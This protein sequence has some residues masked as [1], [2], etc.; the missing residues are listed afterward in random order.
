MQIKK[1]PRDPRP[2]DATD[3]YNDTAETGLDAIP[4][5]TDEPQRPSWRREA[6]SAPRPE[7]TA[8][9]TP[10]S[11]A[12][13]PAASPPAPVAPVARGES[14]VDAHS[15]FDGHY[16]TGQDLRVLGTISGEV[17][18]RGQLTIERDATAKAKI[19]A[20]DVVVRG[21]IEG[22]VTCTGKL[23]I[24][25]SAAV[26]GKV[27]AATLVVH[28]GGSLSGN[29]ETSSAEATAA[30]AGRTS[31]REPA[32]V[33]DEPGAEASVSRG[34]RSRDLPSFALVSSEERSEA[35]RATA[36]AR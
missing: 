27:R 10:P 21:R 33:I 30:P 23:V 12:E 2:G 1:G 15:N 28:E 11:V 32:I 20:H 7:R 22:E 16:E 31:R 35:E 18:C 34:S 5:F 4:T 17:V 19:H 25:A 24:E 14:I 8:I 3:M 29:V 26:T 13:T 6:Y 9:A 36:T